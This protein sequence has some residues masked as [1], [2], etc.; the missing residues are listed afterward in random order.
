M[1]CKSFNVMTVPTKDQ[2]PKTK[3]KKRGSRQ[4]G[5]FSSVFPVIAM[6]AKPTV[7]LNNLIRKT[8]CPKFRH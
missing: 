7:I 8:K 5:E 2:Q 4:A 6:L 1:Q 3:D